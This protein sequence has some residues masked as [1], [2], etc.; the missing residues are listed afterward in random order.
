MANQAAIV[1]SAKAPLEVKSV[2]KY[3][4]GA[5]EILVKNEVISFNPV[6]AKIARLAL[7]PA[8][9]PFIPGL[10]CGGTV[11][12]VGQGVTGFK[13]GDKVAVRRNFAAGG[14][15]YGSFQKFVVA[16][17]EA[18]SKLPD[19][20]DL[21]AAASLI[22][23]LTTTIGLF[24]VRAGLERPSLG[25]SAT[26]KN[27][28]ILIYGGSS[29]VGSLSVQWVAQAGYQVVTTSSPKNKNFVSKLGA[30][31][32]IDHT[33]PQDALVKELVAQGPYDLVADVIALPPTVAVNAAVL[34][35]QG[36]GDVLA[37]LP[38]FG[39]E[40]LPDGVKRV[41]GS[42]PDIIAEEDT[43]GVE[44]WAYRTYFPQSLAKG[45]LIPQPIK[46]ITG[47]LGEGVNKALD[48][49]IAGEVSGVKL[50]ADPW[51]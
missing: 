29:S 8:P 47:G 23:N 38:A 7:L 24:N 34:A 32:V 15:R 1:P 46:K 42:W 6:E 26:A 27:K 30:A 9:Y 4:P 25:D 5:G 48:L 44:E 39:P 2:E 31:A 17:I 22:G 14:N 37:T 20:V 49:M 40:T 36:G 43:T 50:V 11:E 45:K 51:E 16:R 19:G 18:A 13:V 41:F 12:G 3:T 10:S 28:K 21:T 33:Q 35:A